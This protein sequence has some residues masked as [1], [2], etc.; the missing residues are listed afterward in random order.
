MR[1]SNPPHLL[2]VG[3]LAH[4]HESNDAGGEGV[5]IGI[6]ALQVPAGEEPKPS[7]DRR[8]GGNDG[9]AEQHQRR[10]IAR[11]GEPVA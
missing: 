11:A 9:A 4:Q 8:H 6:R 2:G 5:R 1:I 10:L 7:G 3:A